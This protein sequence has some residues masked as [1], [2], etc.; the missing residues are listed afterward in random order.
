MT[1]QDSKHFHCWLEN[2]GSFSRDFVPKESSTP[3][4]IQYSLERAPL[5]SL[6]VFTHIFICMPK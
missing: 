5:S 6:H 4:P 3:K 2:P 1:S